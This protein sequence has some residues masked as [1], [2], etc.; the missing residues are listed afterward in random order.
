MSDD[1]VT[2]IKE[3]EAKSSANNI[4]VAIEAKVGYKAR[5]GGDVGL[6]FI[7]E[8]KITISLQAAKALYTSLGEAIDWIE[9]E[10]EKL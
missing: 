3:F 9:L 4:F 2:K 6:Y 8:P 10:Q 7:P 1:K 5:G